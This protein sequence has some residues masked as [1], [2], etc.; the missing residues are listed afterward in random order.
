MLLK[1]HCPEVEI[2]A[3]CGDLPETVKSIRKLKPNLVFLDIEMPG[4]SGLELLDFFNEEEIDFHIIFTTAY[5]EYA[6]QAFDLSAVGYLLKPIKADK[7]KDTLER[8]KKLEKKSTGALKQLRHNLQHAENKRITLIT[9]YK[10]YFVELNNIMFIKGEGAYSEF[11]LS[12]GEKVLV[13]KNLKH[14]ED[15]LVVDKRF[16]RISKQ[17]IINKDYLLEISKNAGHHVILKNNVSLA[18]SPDKEQ[19]LF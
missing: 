5:S 2:L 10:T 15:M 18:V 14:Y 9:K 3:E 7:L 8:Y 6:V 16:V 1:E 13:S 17:S 4:H 12:G 11:N 19:L